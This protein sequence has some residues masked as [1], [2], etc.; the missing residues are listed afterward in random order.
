MEGRLTPVLGLTKPDSGSAD[1]RVINVD[2]DILDAAI[3]AITGG[4]GGPPS[5]PAGGD[6]TG[7]YPNPQI[8]TGAVSD[9]EVAAANKDGA[10]SSPSMRT[11]GAGATQAAAGN[12]AR[13][14]DARAPTAHHLTHE[15]GG[16]DAMAV[17][18]AAGTGSLRT[19]GTSATSAAAGND[20][21]FSDS[22]PPTGAASGHLTGTYPGPSIANGVVTDTHVAVANKDGAVGTASMRTLGAGATQ[23]AAGNHAHAGMVT[24]PMT[25]AQDLIVGGASGTPTRLGVGASTQVLTVVGGVLT[26]QA[27][28][29]GGMTNPMTSAGDV[30]VGGASGAPGRLGVGTADQV[31]S[32]VA[33][34][35][36]WA[37]AVAQQNLLTNGG[38]E[39][40]QRGAGPFTAGG[41]YTAD[42]WQWVAGTSTVS[43]TQDG[44]G[45]N[46]DVGS[47]YALTAVVGAGTGGSFVQRLENYPQLRGRTV[48]VTARV[49]ST[50]A[51][52]VRV[53]VYDGTAWTDGSF[54][55]GTGAYETVS[56]TV[57]LGAG[58]TAVWVRVNITGAATVQID[59]AVLVVGAV[60]PPYAPL[61]P[62]EDLARC[63]RYYQ[64]WGGTIVNE[65]LTN[66]QCYAT[67]KAQAPLAYPVVMGGVPT[68]T[69]SAPGDFQVAGTAGGAL[70]LTG[71]GGTA[72]TNRSTN[73]DCTVASGLVAGQATVLRTNTLAARLVAEWN[74]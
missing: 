12:D 21:R 22:R 37:A 19:L 63:L 54:N 57:S 49:R 61:H 32:V 9:L 70:T 33:G 8:A 50:V 36:A 74:P 43:V 31:L 24:N 25:T 52:L 6:L 38:Y 44:F 2:L 73:L 16:T 68:I 45:A 65:Y 58:A 13:F 17:N 30:I 15:P 28:V 55:S 3:G 5:G 56:V 23:A 53:G 29:S 1:I 47:Q 42:R 7:S 39:V 64:V 18:A 67:T 40:W 60:A 71:L 34:V 20:A 35:P 51:G 41:A 72:I 27:P 10:P 26:W 4:G 59:N 14:T 69:V 46:V 11:L 62:A 66:G 48:T